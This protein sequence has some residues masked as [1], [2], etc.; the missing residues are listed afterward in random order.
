MYFN[1]WETC[2]VH[3][4]VSR[5][6]FSYSVKSGLHVSCSPIVTPLTSE[7]SS[8]P[9]RS[10]GY[11]TTPLGSAV[12]MQ[13]DVSH[14]TVH[15]LHTSPKEK[16]GSLIYLFLIRIFLIIL[17]LQKQSSL[18]SEPFHRSVSLVYLTA[19]AGIKISTTSPVSATIWNFF[20]ITKR[21]K[22]KT[23]SH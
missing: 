19:N 10:H 15:A 7:L 3:T 1:Y 14:S 12:T 11:K 17:R 4:A 6:T 8:D 13:G 18:S 16:T 21:S 2:S 20:G 9:A 23:K 22:L 5:T